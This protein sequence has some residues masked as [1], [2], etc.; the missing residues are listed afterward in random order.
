MV[1]S[2]ETVVIAFILFVF[3]MIFGGYILARD[4][5]KSKKKVSL[6]A[7]LYLSVLCSRTIVYIVVMLYSILAAVAELHACG[8]SATLLCLIF[9]AIISLFE[10]MTSYAQWPLLKKELQNYLSSHKSH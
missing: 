6:F 10:A 2:L 9:T 7:K 8:I 5:I 1:L 3:L 4:V